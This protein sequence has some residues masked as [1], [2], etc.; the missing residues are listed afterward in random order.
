MTWAGTT[1]NE[2][3]STTD[4]SACD[5][6]V[7]A[8]AYTDLAGSGSPGINVLLHMDWDAGAKKFGSFV[9]INLN[10]VTTGTYA[11]GIGAMESAV[12]WKQA[13]GQCLASGGSVTLSKYDGIGGVAAGTFQFTG[14][15]AVGGASCPATVDGSFSSSV[16]DGDAFTP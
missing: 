1:Y 6:Q 10:G 5:P 9:S 15:S 14:L 11:Y 13:S 12:I 16:V 3:Q 7:M 4:P 8:A 2:T